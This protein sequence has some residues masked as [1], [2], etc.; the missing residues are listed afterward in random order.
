[1]NEPLFGIDVSNLVKVMGRVSSWE[2]TNKD[3]LT[4]LPSHEANL[5]IKMAILEIFL[6]LLVWAN[7]LTVVMQSGLIEGIAPPWWQEGDHFSLTVCLKW[8]Q[9]IIF[10]KEFIFERMQFLACLSIYI[11]IRFIFISLVL[12]NTW[13]IMIFSLIIHLIIKL[14]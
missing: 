12:N 7:I 5:R 14:K 9:L 6:V 8:D 1:M 13:M 11:L 2:Q 4:K 3:S 10:W